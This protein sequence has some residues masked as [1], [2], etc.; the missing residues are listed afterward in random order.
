MKKKRT[1]ILLLQLALVIGFSFS[2]YSY[3]QNEVKDTPVLVYERDLNVGEQADVRIVEIPASGIQKNMLTVSD[4]VK[5]MGA[6]KSVSEEKVIEYAETLFVNRDVKAGHYIY[7]DELVEEGKIDPFETMDLSR[8]RKV[9]LPISY[10]D[11]FGGNIKRGDRIDLIYTGQGET[12]KGASMANFQY[13]KV[14]LQNVLV[15]S[16]TTGNGYEFV[17]HSY[18]VEGQMSGED[19]SVDG[20]AEELAV[21]TLAVTLDQAEEIEARKASGSISF[22]ARFDEHESYQTLGY[23]IGDYDKIPTGKMSAETDKATIND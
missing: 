7:D 21:I 17:D 12:V 15:Y 1:L 22:V 16:V 9:S 10:V 2:F 5:E 13:S 4:L 20:E 8:Y 11:G 23:V 3:V 14:F 6:K 18:K 19:I